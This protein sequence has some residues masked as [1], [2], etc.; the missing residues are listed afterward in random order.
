MRKKSFHSIRMWH[1]LHS[2]RLKT[3]ECYIKNVLDFDN[4][5]L[6]YVHK[7]IYKQSNESEYIVDSV[8]YVLFSFP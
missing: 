4:L 3:V 5:A 1:S 8:T 6:F 7:R 2:Q